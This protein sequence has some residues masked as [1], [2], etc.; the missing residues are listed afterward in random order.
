MLKKL[1]LKDGNKTSRFKLVQ[2]VKDNYDQ[3]DG[4]K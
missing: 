2:I 1:F 4:K 3:T